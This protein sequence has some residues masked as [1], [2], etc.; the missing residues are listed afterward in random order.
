MRTATNWLEMPPALACNVAHCKVHS[1]CLYIGRGSPYGNPFPMSD[2]GMRDAVVAAFREWLAGQPELLRLARK[3]LPG[4]V[5]GC[6]CAPRSCHGD[7]LSE[8]AAGLW[9][10]LIPDEP[11]LVFGSN[12]AGRHGT[13]AARAALA[14]YGAV[15]GCGKGLT[16][17]SYAL[18]TKDAHLAPLP[19][20]RV[21]GELAELSAF[22]GDHPGQMFR[23][24]RVGCGLAGHPEAQ[25][26]D[27]L[28]EH[29]PANVLLPGVWERQRQ[30]DLARVVVAGSR[31]FGDYALMERKLDA[32]L[33]RLDRVEI[34]SGGA[35]GA[36]SLGERYAIERGLRLRRMPAYW[37]AFGR[38]AGHIRN[39][40]MSWYGTHL[41]A[42]WDGSS[43]GTKGMIE[44]AKE[45]GLAVRVVR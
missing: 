25:I 39:R 13:G 22:A 14:Q 23:M 3:A 19:L 24:T 9:D 1:D 20:D 30:P 18:P 5:L 21:L 44:L 12:L 34:V 36:D 41:V 7:V 2:E 11:L 8:V 32:L 16:G 15:P 26:R 43:P 4:Q 40:R 42:F 35:K 17:H 38:A 28:L 37:E 6:F 27:Y 45:D 33:S 10:H 31:G 29:A